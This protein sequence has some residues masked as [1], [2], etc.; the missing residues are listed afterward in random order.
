M[1]VAGDHDTDSGIVTS[2]NLR[3]HRAIETVEALG[4]EAN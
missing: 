1:A 4:G 2:V 3:L